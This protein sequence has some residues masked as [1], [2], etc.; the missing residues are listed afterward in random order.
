MIGIKD[1][2]KVVQLNPVQKMHILRQQLKVQKGKNKF[3]ELDEAERKVFLQLVNDSFNSTSKQR[4]SQTLFNSVPQTNPMLVNGQKILDLECRGRLDMD[5]FYVYADFVKPGL[6]MYSVKDTDEQRYIHRTVVRNREEKLEAYQKITFKAL[7]NEFE[8][9]HSVFYNW[10]QERRKDDKFYAFDRKMFKLKGLV[11][12]EKDAV[13][14][15]LRENYYDFKIMFDY[16]RAVSG[17][18]YKISY[19]E[20]VM[21][22]EKMR[23]I[24]KKAKYGVNQKFQGLDEHD[25]K[26]IFD[27]TRNP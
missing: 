17:G 27:E 7:A 25:L 10:V 8:H 13:E 1:F 22:A 5:D 3:N 6:H 21:L 4:W 19:E 2:C 9:Q 20:F 12:E 16:Y 23:L 15:F 26:E 11:K 18:I 24:D 14:T